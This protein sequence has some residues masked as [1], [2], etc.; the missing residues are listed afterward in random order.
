MEY[1]D[2]KV[3]GRYKVRK[4]EYRS[5]QNLS[6]DV[7]NVFPCQWIDQK[8]ICTKKNTGSKTADFELLNKDSDI[9][10]VQK[11]VKYFSWCID[12]IKE[13]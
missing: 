2:I 4:H 11:N 7:I 8:I 13:E 9:P 12:E 10:E 3:G 5:T 1:K 6:A